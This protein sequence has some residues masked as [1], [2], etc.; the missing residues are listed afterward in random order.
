MP[1]PVP[2]PH[3]ASPEFHGD[4]WALTEKHRA[5]P[6]GTAAVSPPT[7]V[8]WFAQPHSGSFRFLPPD[9]IGISCL[10]A[11]SNE[12]CATTRVIVSPQPN[13]P[14]M[15]FL[16]IVRHLSKRQR[17]CAAQSHFRWEEPSLRSQT[18]DTA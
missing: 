12:I 13:G 17:R 11:N 16:G 14:A 15:M 1:A 18:Y 9:Q 10:G 7:R 5:Q 4:G 8:E 2:A 3:L 6:S